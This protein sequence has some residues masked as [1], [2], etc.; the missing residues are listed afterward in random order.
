MFARAA[1]PAVQTPALFQPS[2]K[3][4]LMQYLKP[5]TT[6]AIGMALGYFV[7]PKIMAKVGG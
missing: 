5:W 6:L 1:G 7:V 2:R 3:D 4:T